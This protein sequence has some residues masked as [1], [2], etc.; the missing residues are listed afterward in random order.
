ME[1]NKFERFR[2]IVNCYLDNGDVAWVVGIRRGSTIHAGDREYTVAGM[3]EQ[4]HRKN[5]E[6]AIPVYI[7]QDENEKEYNAVFVS[8]EHV[9][10]GGKLV[11]WRWSDGVAP[12]Q[13]RTKFIA[14]EDDDDDDS[15]EE[16]SGSE[17]EDV[18]SDEEVRDDDVAYLKSLRKPTVHV[19][20][21]SKPLQ[22]DLWCCR[23]QVYMDKT[24]FSTANQKDKN[25]RTRY[26]LFHTSSSSFGQACPL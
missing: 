17:A 1:F 3:S 19:N 21:R 18:G 22:N 13:K 4:T 7:V 24:A 6:I 9:L 20:R 5:D 8:D 10:L 14:P 25:D 16:P 15:S 26:C 11:M 12:P 23:C 2:N